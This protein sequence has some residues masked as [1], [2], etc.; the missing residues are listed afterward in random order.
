MTSPIPPIHRT[1]AAVTLLAAGCVAA[2]PANGTTPSFRSL[3]GKSVHSVHETDDAEAQAL[4]AGYAKHVSDVEAVAKGMDRSELPTFAAD[5]PGL[6]EF[7]LALDGADQFNSPRAPQSGTDEPCDPRQEH[8]CDDDGG[9]DGGGDGGDDEPNYPDAGTE[10]D[11]PKLPRIAISNS[12]PGADLPIIEKAVERAHYNVWRFNQLMEHVVSVHYDVGQTQAKAIWETGH[13]H[14]NSLSAY[15][16]PYDIKLVEAIYKTVNHVFEEYLTHDGSFTLACY[17]YPVFGDIFKPQLLAAKLASACYWTEAYATSMYV[18]LP[19]LHP[20]YSFPTWELCPSFG[21]DPYGYG[22]AGRGMIMSH[23]LYHWLV[24]D[25]G[26]LKDKFDKDACGPNKECTY[27]EEIIDLATAYPSLGGRNIHG[28]A[29]F[30]W[31]LSDLYYLNNCDEGFCFEEGLC[32]PPDEEPGGTPPIPDTC[33]DQ[34][35][36]TCEWGACAPVNNN[37]SLGEQL[38]P[39]SAAHPDGDFSK[40]TFCYGSELVCNRL[41]DEGRCVPCGPGQMLGCPCDTQAQ[42]D[43]DGADLG[44]YGSEETGWKGSTGTCWPNDDGPPVFQ[45]AEGCEGRTDYLGNADYY[46]YHDTNVVS[47]AVCLHADCSEPAAFCAVDDVG[48]VC[49]GSACLPECAVDDDCAD[50]YGW[51]VGTTCFSGECLPPGGP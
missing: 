21:S 16:G 23:E 8:N 36:G 47:E 1:L 18:G 15:F 43:G 22:E 51:P 38:D 20:N 32:P 49:E 48:M 9:D 44:C 12:C 39:Y 4:L 3:P 6:G 29:E 28:Y 35:L 40:D 50:D 33:D 5:N 30:G 19:N 34:E 45:C 10:C 37:P 27:Q 17:K 31:T 25:Y 24:N 7:L 11:L 14:Q 41:G 2:E 46:C 42:C 13:E 26:L